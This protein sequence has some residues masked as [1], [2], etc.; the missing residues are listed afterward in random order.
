M[1]L[2]RFGE[3]GKAVCENCEEVVSTTFAYRDVPLGDGPGKVRDILVA[4]CDKCGSLVAVPPQS[5]PAIKAARE[6]A[7]KS[8][9]VS[10]PAPY[11]EA[12]DLAAFRIDPNASSEFRKRLL[13]YYI[14]RCA[15]EEDGPVAM[16]SIIDNTSPNFVVDRAIPRRR[17]SF[18]VT[19][20]LDSDIKRIMRISNLNRTDVIK[21]L[22][23]LIDKDIVR[24]RKPKHLTELK[25]LAAVAAC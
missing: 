18:K 5:T 20:R 10:L 9:E 11:V 21:G 13:A 19:P 2:H 1:K 12:L 23:M 4:L 25:R 17:L 22:V 16:P 15:S 8:I 3:K 14:H 6:T 24:P 7:T